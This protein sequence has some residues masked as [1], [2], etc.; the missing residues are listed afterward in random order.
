[1]RVLLVDNDAQAASTIQRALKSN[2]AVL[3]HV[4][5]GE[6][7]FQLAKRYDYDALVMDLMLPD[8]DG[9]EVIRRLRWSSIT[10]PILVLSSLTRPQAKVKAFSLGAD[11]FLARPFDESELSA[12]IQ[13]LVRR[14]KGLSHSR[15]SLGLTMLDMESNLVT[16]SGQTVHL[17]EKEY[18]IL[19]LL[20]LRSGSIVAKES[21]L[22]HLYGG[23]DEPDIK[24]IDV[25]VCKLRR[26]LA[27]AGAADVITT[28]WGRGYIVRDAVATTQPALRP[29][30]AETGG[31]GMALI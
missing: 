28:V 25:F 31:Q 16:V 14:S 11:D 12:R 8:T 6:E 7:A 1:M 30:G 26:K 18:R 2:G 23:N 17:T 9:Y 15:I 10:V 20:F 21:F 13:A 29:P 19:E 4:E 3:E 24:I 27:Q 22:N 5:T